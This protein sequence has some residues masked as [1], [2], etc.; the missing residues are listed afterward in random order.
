MDPNVALMLVHLLSN[1]TVPDLGRSMQL[2]A[3]CHWPQ[4]A[5]C[6]DAQMAFLCLQHC[7]GA[8]QDTQ[9]PPSPQGDFAVSVQHQ[10]SS[11]HVAHLGQF[12]CP[13]PFGRCPN[14]AS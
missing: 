9:V 13:S 10:L 1:S 11:G 7:K 12:C 3:A 14:Y 4:H 8:L 5:I 6:S 2:A